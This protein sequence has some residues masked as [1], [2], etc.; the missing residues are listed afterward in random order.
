MVRMVFGRNDWE[1]GW[2]GWLEGVVGR[3]GWRGWLEGWLKG[4][5][6]GG[7]WR[8]WL[9][10]V[11]GRGGWRSGWKSEVEMGRLRWLV[12]EGVVT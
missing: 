4:V 11:V 12:R 9:E 3:G 10:G 6:G 8:G 1:G 2:R 5:V 7:G